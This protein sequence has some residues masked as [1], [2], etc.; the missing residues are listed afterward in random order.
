MLG[1]DRSDLVIV[2][3]TG[4]PVRAQQQHIAIDEREADT[5]D[6]DLGAHADRAGDDGAVRMLRRLG[7]GDAALVDECLHQRVVVGELHDDTVTQQVGARVPDVDEVRFGAVDE[8]RRQCGAHALEL[9]F[10]A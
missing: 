9:R 4:Q 10:A 7:A 5:V 6:L 2:D 8:D 3:D 1:D